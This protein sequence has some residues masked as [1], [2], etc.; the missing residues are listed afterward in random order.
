MSKIFI[1]SLLLLFGICLQAQT[2]QIRTF[3]VEEGLPQSQIYAMIIDHNH[4]IWI[5]T[6]GGGL[7]TFDGKNY[8]LIRDTSFTED[9][10][11]ALL[12]D[13]SE[14]ILVGTDNGL[15]VY[16]RIKFNKVALP[17]KGYQLAV[18]SMCMD[19]KGRPW[20]G[21]TVGIFY[22]EKDKWISYSDEVQSLK[23]NV[24]ALHC[25]GDGIMWAGSDQGVFK[26][27][28]NGVVKHSIKQGLTSNK[29]RSIADYEGSLIVGTYG[30]GINAYILKNGER[31]WYSMGASNLIINHLQVENRAGKNRIWAAT[32]SKGMM[33]I[34]PVKNDISFI[35]SNDG[36]STNHCRLSIQ[37]DWNNVW[38]ATSGGGLNKIFK[39][40]FN[41]QNEEDG[42]KGN[43]F[44]ALEASFDGGVWCT[45]NTGGISKTYIDSIKNYSIEELK[46]VKSKSLLEDRNQILW[47]GTE[48]KGLYAYHPK[49]MMQLSGDQGLSDNWVKEI[50][51]DPNGNIWCATVSGISKISYEFDGE[52]LLINRI[53]DFSKTKG[54]PDDR[55]NC[56]KIDNRNRIWFGTQNGAVGYIFNDEIFWSQTDQNVIKSA[57][58]SICFDDENRIWVA[59]EGNGI[60]YSKLDE[61]FM[62]FKS[63]GLNDGLHSKNVYLIHYDRKGRIWAGAGNGIDE[64]IVSEDDELI[65]I[66]HYGINEGFKGGETCSNAVTTDLQDRIWIGTLDGVNYFQSEQSFK[67]DIIPQVFISDLSIFYKSISNTE[68]K[69]QI[70]SL[71]GAEKL[72]L[73]PN[74]NH[75]NFNFNAINLL[76]PDKVKFSFKMEG[77]D[78]EW[79][80]ISKKNEATY[81][82]LPPGNYT[83]KVKAFN[84][85][86]LSS[87][88]AHFDFLIRTPFYKTWW[89]ITAIIVG[90]S[91]IIFLFL[92]IRWKA[93][94]EHVKAENERLEYERNVLE[95]EQ[96]AL[97]LQM[98]PHFI[99]NAMNSVQALIAKNDTKEARYYLAKFS[100]LMRKILENSRHSLISIADEIEALDNY[101]NLEK[102]SSD[103]SFDYE[104]ILDDK[105]TADAYGIPP[106]LLQPFAENAIVHGLKEIEHRG[107]ITISFEYFEKYIECVVQDNGRGRVAASEVRQQKS[108]YHKSTALIITQ[109]RL[110]SEEELDY[111]PFEM[112]DL[113]H[114]TGTKVIVR[115]P[116]I[117]VF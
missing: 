59:T 24:S 112:L 27:K 35:G 32:Q 76:S 85:D 101:L 89:F 93:Y 17:N 44:Y 3:S 82:N 9:K 69:H 49:F 13:S 4:Q 84:E 46:N 103:N 45:T 106:L 6:K 42:H 102:I 92:W 43:M 72:L 97:R 48:G 113:N 29:I 64:I 41:Y 66:K 61:D 91:G 53:K 107:K 71:S 52:T 12:E 67:N 21:T 40:F 37:D 68:Y 81:S 16:D 111:I 117:E 116:V 62:A 11:F 110:G 104:I 88:E 56:L 8:S 70:S 33:I 31:K 36:M 20:V 77:F 108:S 54:L 23:F 47:I 57:V 7:C 83:F 55:I 87:E 79:S 1:T 75:L 5:G 99:F 96:K 18:S 38:V 51:E 63:I 80:P 78:P 10:I 58:K 115:I 34:D 28:K 30:G 50:A 114:P 100:K 25:D 2:K 39:P 14:N 22:R 98:N 65:K 105:I 15:F 95:L 74:D 109:E 86:G 94:N 60:H 19:K 90:I 73:K 26:L